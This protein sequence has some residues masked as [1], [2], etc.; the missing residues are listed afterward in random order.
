M[1]HPLQRR[2]ASKMQH[3]TLMGWAGYISDNSKGHKNWK[4]KNKENE[5]DETLP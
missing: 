1:V 2:S 3:P 4:V 5:M